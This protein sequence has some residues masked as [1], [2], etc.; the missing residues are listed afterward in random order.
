MVFAH[1]LANILMGLRLHTEGSEILRETRPSIVVSNHQHNYDILV[2]GHF[3][4]KYM[5]VLGKSQLA[6]IPLFGQMF[7]L[8][9]NILIKRGHKT[10]AKK[11][12]QKVME[13]VI[14]KKLTVLIFAEGTRNKNKELLPFKKGAFITAIDAQ[15]PIIPCSVS[16]YYLNGDIKNKLTFHIYTRIHEPIPTIGMTESDLPSLMMKTRDI[17]QAGIEARNKNYELS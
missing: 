16:Q 3:F 12:M 9:G 5:A 6:F 2:G 13:M 8:C 11:T 1:R 17:I 15:I 10:K 7:V 14:K 4:S